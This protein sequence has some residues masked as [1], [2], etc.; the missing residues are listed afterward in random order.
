[1]LDV[2][3]FKSLNDT[4]GHIAG[5]QCLQAAASILHQN[6]RV[7]CDNVGRYGGEE[8]LVVLRKTSAETAA[9]NAED[10][11]Q[12][13]SD[14]V[15]EIEKNQK[16]RLTCTFGVATHKVDEQ[17]LA[18]PST[19]LIQKADQAMYIGK[20]TGKNCVIQYDEDTPSFSA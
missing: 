2:D 9:K 17:S 7:D 11:R 12:K 14:A 10:L 5:D 3:N 1:M 19:L 8:F 4:Y 13:I 15:L 20:I 6:I 16:L 18:A